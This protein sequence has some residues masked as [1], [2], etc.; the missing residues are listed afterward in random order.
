MGGGKSAGGCIVGQ[1]GAGAIWGVR[2]AMQGRGEGE[3]DA[4]WGQ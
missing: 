3:K 1:E 2:R 4:A